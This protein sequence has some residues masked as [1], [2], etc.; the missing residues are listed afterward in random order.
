[1]LT[2]LGS[3]LV[4]VG[5][6]PDRKTRRQNPTLLGITVITRG[7]NTI[8]TFKSSLVNNEITTNAFE[9]NSLY[10]RSK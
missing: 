9:D 7:A 3:K 10:V 5:S 6:N 8:G 2:F 4:L 1:M